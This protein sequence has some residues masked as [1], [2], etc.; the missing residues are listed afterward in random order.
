MSSL[1]HALV[2]LV[3]TPVRRGIVR[4]GN[5]YASQMPATQPGFPSQE[6]S[7]RTLETLGWSPRACIDVGAYHGEW[8]GMFRSFFPNCSMLMI[9]AQQGKQ[10]QLDEAATRL[11]PGVAAEIA[12]L[13]SQDDVEVDFAE[14]ETG[15]SVFQE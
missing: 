8:A 15:S 13:G 1:K 9:E 6:A 2:R 3:P 4:L 7:L 12:L 14:M 5:Y 10:R 11:G